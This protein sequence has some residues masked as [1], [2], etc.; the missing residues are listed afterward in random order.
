MSETTASHSEAPEQNALA[1]LRAG[2]AAWPPIDRQFATFLERLAGRPDPALALA[3]AL[4]S[5][6]RSAGH[7]CLELTRLANPAYAAQVLTETTLTGFPE[8]RAWAAALRQSPVVGEPGQFRP[9][10]LD[11]KGRLY[12][13]RYWVCENAVAQ[14]ILDRANQRADGVDE[15][16][17]RAGLNRFFPGGSGQTPDGQAVASEVA[18]RRKFTVVSG[19]PGT[20]KTR[21]VAV[22]LALLLEQAG[23]G[24]CRIALAAPTGKAAARLQ[25][26]IQRLGPSLPC[27][28]AVKARLPQEAFTLHR[29]LGIGIAAARNRYSASNPLPFEVVV[30]DEASMV[31]L[32]LMG[33]LLEALPAQARLILLGDKEQLAS[34]E[35]GAVL[36]D[37]CQD[38]PADH[39][40]TDCL[41]R[42][43]RNYRFGPNE[44]FLVF[45][46]AV[47]AGDADGA[48]AVCRAAVDPRE[49]VGLF[50]A[51]LAAPGRL[52]EALREW[53]IHAFHDSV[54]TLEPRAALQALNQVRLLAAL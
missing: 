32:I 52:K 18:V 44:S 45:S 24:R 23:A 26:S 48:L 33:K 31:D 51:P 39:A 15:S 53:V 17:L 46:K 30:V 28:E 36:G 50:R 54:T 11:P 2:S 6:S 27:L 38:G 10:I 4:L 8:A 22:I 29:L 20:G 9:L 3:G 16:L 7:T 1:S 25:E 21:T 35:A 34:V 5:R 47:N 37:L 14:A 42:L 40:L 19:G 43:E 13:Q 41:V 49:E 12:L